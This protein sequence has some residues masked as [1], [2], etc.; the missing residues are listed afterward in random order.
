MDVRLP[1][2]LAVLPGQMSK[3]P[4]NKSW[5]V[6]QLAITGYYHIP[7]PDKLS[8]EDRSLLLAFIYT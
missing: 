1:V 2:Q 4:N 7:L 3:Q 5:E 6:C 8:A